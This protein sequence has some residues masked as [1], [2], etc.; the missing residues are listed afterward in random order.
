METMGNR[1]RKARLNKDYTLEELASLINKPYQLI[2]QYEK[3][4]S[5][6]KENNMQLIANAL[7][8][9]EMWLKYGSLYYEEGKYGKTVICNLTEDD[10][11]EKNKKL[12][13]KSNKENES[14]N[15]EQLKEDI[16]FKI[17]FC[18]KDTLYI[19]SKIIDSLGNIDENK[20]KYIKE[21][22]KYNCIK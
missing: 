17:H 15:H 12:N 16:E 7:E 20:D 22:M 19:V 21:S 1:I 5:V 8:V 18:D 10:I 14:D 3:D 9:D 6:P 4:Q 13:S 2:H 11:N